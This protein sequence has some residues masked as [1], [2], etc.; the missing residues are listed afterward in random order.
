MLRQGFFDP[1][2]T[3]KSTKAFV[4]HVLYY[5]TPRN[6]LEQLA[7]ILDQYREIGSAASH[8]V[9]AAKMM[10]VVQGEGA[11]TLR[12]LVDSALE[13]LTR[14]QRASS[15]PRESPANGSGEFYRFTF[16]RQPDDE[17]I[18]SLRI[19]FDVAASEVHEG[20]IGDLLDLL[21]D[22]TLEAT[23]G[24]LKIAVRL[25]PWQHS[26][27]LFEIPG[28]IYRVSGGEMVLA[29]TI[30][31]LAAARVL[32]ENAGAAPQAGSLLLV[33]DGF[34]NLS[35]EAVSLY[36]KLADS[37]G[38]QLVCTTSSI[39]PNLLTAFP[40]IVALRP[41]L[42]DGGKRSISLSRAVGLQD[43]VRFQSS[44]DGSKSQVAAVMNMSPLGEVFDVLPPWREALHSV[45]SGVEAPPDQELQAGDILLP[46][47]LNPH[48]GNVPMTT[49]GRSQPVPA[50]RFSMVV[51]RPKSNLRPGEI[52]FYANYFG[53]ALFLAESK[54]KDEIVVLEEQPLT[55]ILLPRPDESTLRAIHDIDV[56]AEVFEG[57]KREALATVG[58]FF[59]ASDI[60]SARSQ[61]I[62]IGRVTR[63]RREAGGVTDDLESRLRA[64]LPYPI[65]RQWRNVQAANRDAAGYSLILECAESVVAYCAAVGLSFA[66]AKGVRVAR[67]SAIAARFRAG[68]MGMTFGDWRALLR[69]LATHGRSAAF[70]ADSAIA[71]FAAFSDSPIASAIDRLGALRNDRAHRR[72]PADHEVADVF[73]QARAELVAVLAGVEWLVDYSL[74]H[75][76][77]SHWD[78]FGNESRVVVRELMGDHNVV[79]PRELAVQGNVEVG[80]SY[81]LDRFGGQQLLRPFLKARQCGLC[82]QLSVFVV[83]R[84]LPTTEEVEYLALDHRH[85]ERVSDMRQ[86]LEHVGLL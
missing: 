45:A 38:N 6:N 39:D 40:L 22:A 86:A 35:D 32:A 42:V 31:Y 1:G 9:E 71:H 27:R 82:G 54:E 73:D 70:S 3:F 64:T 83:D 17:L 48:K 8:N 72:G 46:K 29:T 36:L 26:E 61:M 66:N 13:N 59:K 33:D 63:Q 20:R 68:R 84:W 60:A 12:T 56:A 30:R 74:C 47:L 16:V 50:A 62:E 25:S 14:F 10:E 19:L 58:A 11:A 76:E 69:E 28:D 5:V 80:S 85:T 81:V 18:K 55:Q 79:A 65:A 23:G 2:D 7:S 51:L 75:V 67:L 53:S 57:W 4:R 77:A 41:R 21:V 52:L 24:N 15:L 78:S 43:I 34:R 44:T 49:V 37:F